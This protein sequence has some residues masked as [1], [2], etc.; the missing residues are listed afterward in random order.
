MLSCYWLI[1]VGTVVTFC[2]LIWLANHYW[3]FL[4]ETKNV[5]YGTHSHIQINNGI[6]ILQS[7]L[8]QE[9]EIVSVEWTYQCKEK[10]KMNTKTN[11]NYELYWK[12]DWQKRVACVNIWNSEIWQYKMCTGLWSHA[13]SWTINKN[14]KS[15]RILCYFCDELQIDEISETDYETIIFFLFSIDFFWCGD[16]LAI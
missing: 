2:R 16:E 10:R 4:I 15:G 12:L 3:A 6:I 11:W 1:W 14:N 8:T 9:N 13:L 7:H 5:D